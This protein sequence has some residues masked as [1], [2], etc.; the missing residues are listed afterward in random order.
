[1]SDVNDKDS[2]WFCLG[3][4]CRF[5][6]FWVLGK[7]VVPFGSRFLD[8]KEPP[9]RKELMQ[10]KKN[11]HNRSRRNRSNWFKKIVPT[12]S[13][14]KQHWTHLQLIAKNPFTPETPEPEDDKRACFISFVRKQSLENDRDS[15]DRKTTTIL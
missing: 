2:F 13:N 5:V 15:G 1:M 11:D 4:C 12:N 3:L 10:N 7:I 9:V 6:T 14:R 8:C